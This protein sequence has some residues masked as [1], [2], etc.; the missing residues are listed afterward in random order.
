M[1]KLVEPQGL[2]ITFAPSYAQYEVWEALEPNYCDKCHQHG[3]ELKLTGYDSRGNPIHEA[4]CSHCGNSNI[5]ENILQGGAA[6][7]GKSYLGCAWLASSCI[8]FPGILMAVARLTL[9]SLRETTWQTLLRLLNQWGSKADVN[10]HI[11]NQY[12]K[13]TF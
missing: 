4:V 11:N 12:N 13:L 10:Y 5:S 8:R 3:L 9:K 7:G 1:R 2:K 6:G